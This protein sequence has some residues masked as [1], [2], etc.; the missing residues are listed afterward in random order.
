[1]ENEKEISK[2][3]LAR[4]PLY[5]HFLQEEASKGAQYISST[6]I[7][8]N[9]SVSTVLVR[10]DLAIFRRTLL[11]F[12][13]GAIAYPKGLSP[14]SKPQRGARSSTLLPNRA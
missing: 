9:I 13:L 1:M 6:V 14:L 3:T 2:A 4:M 8:Q 7:A 12:P 5:L 10:K 11:E